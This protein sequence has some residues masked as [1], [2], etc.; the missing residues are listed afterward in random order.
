VGNP[1][2]IIIHLLQQW[3]LTS[4]VGFQAFEGLSFL[5]LLL[6]SKFNSFLVN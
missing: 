4:I 1:P 5:S 6:V 2:P 3:K